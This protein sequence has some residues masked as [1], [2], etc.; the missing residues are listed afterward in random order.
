M[1]K[2][3]NIVTQ[4]PNAHFSSFLLKV[5][6]TRWSGTEWD[7]RQLLV[8][9]AVASVNLPFGKVTAKFWWFINAFFN[10]SI[11]SMWFNPFF[12]CRPC[13]I[14]WTNMCGILDRARV[15]VAHGLATNL[16]MDW[17]VK[18]LFSSCS[19]E[20][21]ITMAVSGLTGLFRSLT[22]C[23]QVSIHCFSVGI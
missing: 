1:W 13:M 16:Y 14:K 23:S 19:A 7:L 9:L 21:G 18:L 22:L 6:A 10:K 20:E 17:C 3:S 8:K 15:N 5:N 4:M 12:M 2:Y 11:H